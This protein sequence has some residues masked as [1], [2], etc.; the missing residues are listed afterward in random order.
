[1]VAEKINNPRSFGLFNDIRAYAP[2]YQLQCPS[3]RDS[4]LLSVTP[5]GAVIDARRQAVQL[6]IGKRRRLPDVP[7][8]ASEAS[9]I[10]R[11]KL[12]EG[13]R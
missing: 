11:E 6:G 2:A 8:A 10:L 4:A 9:V 13:H 5:R 1:M 12:Q 7:V 3:E